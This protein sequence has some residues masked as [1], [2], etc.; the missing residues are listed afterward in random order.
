M[1]PAG[2]IKCSRAGRDTYG[3]WTYPVH[4]C[5]PN[6]T[7]NRARCGI[8]YSKINSNKTATGKANTPSEDGPVFEWPPPL[9]VH[10][11]TLDGIDLVCWL[12]TDCRSAAVVVVTFVT[13]SS[14]PI[15]AAIICARIH[16]HRL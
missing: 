1:P 13:T 10:T 8:A 14:P 4:G 15:S 11:E 2:C 5:D 16:M 3:F 7:S 6:T 9:P 12:T